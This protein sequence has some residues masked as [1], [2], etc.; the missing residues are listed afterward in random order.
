M[1]ALTYE[2]PGRRA[3]REVPEP[4]IED[5]E[6]AIVR[7]EAATI[8]G[9]DLRI[10]AG[11]VPDV[12]V[13]RVLGHEAIGTV[14]Q[15]GS[16]IG[17]FQAGDRV[18]ISCIAS[19]GRC[20]YCR[21]SRNGQCLAGGGWLLG[22]RVD[23]VHADRVRVPFAHR[24]LQHLPPGLSVEQA[25][26]LADVLPTAYELGVLNGKVEP[27]AAVAIIGGGPIG[28]A[29]AITA[30]LFSPAWVMV[31]ERLEKR[32]AIAAAMGIDHVVSSGDEARQLAFDLT[33][34][35]GVDVAMEAVGSPGA[36]ELCT[37]LVRAGG[38]VA[39][40]GVHASPATLHL[41]RVWDRDIT[42]RTGVVNGSSTATLMSQL[43]NGHLRT[44]GLFTHR[45]TMDEIQ[46]AYDLFARP[47]V[48]GALK[49]LLTTD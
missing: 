7:V 12:E 31:V 44:E 42:W 37:D 27:G 30:Q 1:K 5:Y 49:V 23:G 33:G 29:A 4:E 8:C 14:E 38:R 26:L 25:L 16:G 11:D 34:G 45:F 32:R 6:D 18:V 35:L 22:R 43:A 40:L 36:F 20:Q 3:W 15:V 47:E 28:I 13:G 10:L 2:G 24:S 41:E 17:E 48:T 9:T 39:N 46:D 21:E 19:C